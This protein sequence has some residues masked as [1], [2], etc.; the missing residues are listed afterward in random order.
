MKRRVRNTMLFAGSF[1]GGVLLFAGLKALGDGERLGWL[2]LLGSVAA[3]VFAL[4][5]GRRLRD[6]VRPPDGP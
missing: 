3:F 6:R 5:P 1:V 2:Y 4:A